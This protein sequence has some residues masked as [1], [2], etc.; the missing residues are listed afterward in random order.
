MFIEILDRLK[1]ERGP[2]LPKKKP[3]K[4]LK[5]IRDANFEKAKPALENPDEVREMFNTGG[6]AGSTRLFVQR[7]ID[8]IKKDYLKGMSVPELTKKYLPNM[9]GFSTTLDT[10]LKENLTEAEKAK[11]P[12]I[13]GRNKFQ[14]VMKDPKKLKAILEDIPKMANKEV[15]EKHK[16]SGNTLNEIKNKYNLK[17][18]KK[19]KKPIDPKVTERI[20][21]TVNAIEAV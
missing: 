5:K 8:K 19:I 6:S 7:N 17:F 12:D 21:K 3:E 9:K 20:K 2:L 4:K 18:G 13:I 14:Q 10:V 16:I 15:L 11:R 1:G